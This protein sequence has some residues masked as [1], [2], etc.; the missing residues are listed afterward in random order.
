[1]PYVLRHGIGEAASGLVDVERN[2]VRID[3]EPELHAGAGRPRFDVQPDRGGIGM[4]VGL[5]DLHGAPAAE[6]P[7]DADHRGLAERGGHT[8]IVGERGLDDLLLDGPVERHVDLLPLVVLAQVDERILFG[9]LAEGDA[10]PVPVP[11]ITRHDG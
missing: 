2:E 10:Q 9:E 6:G 3:A 5:Q 4:A 7:L 8:E 1:M 11:R